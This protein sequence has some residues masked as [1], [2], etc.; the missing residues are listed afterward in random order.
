[1]FNGVDTK[2][3]YKDYIEDCISCGYELSSMRS[4]FGF[5]NTEMLDPEMMDY[6]LSDDELK[7][8]CDCFGLDYCT[9]KAYW[10]NTMGFFEK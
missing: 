7:M 2:A 4:Y 1:M 10:E 8:W 3:L 9:L 5:L 6:C